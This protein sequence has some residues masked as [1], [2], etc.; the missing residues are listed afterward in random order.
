MLG[1]RTIPAAELGSGRRPQD[2][3]THHEG[4]EGHGEKAAGPLP[5]PVFL[6]VL[7]ALRGEGEPSLSLAGRSKQLGFGL[8]RQTVVALLLHQIEKRGNGRNQA[9]PVRGGNH[10][11]QPLTA[12]A[13]GLSQ[14][15]AFLV[16]DEPQVIA[17]NATIHQVAML[18]CRTIPAAELGSGRK[19]R[20]GKKIETAHP[21]HCGKGFP[22]RKS[23]Q[24]MSRTPVMG[25]ATRSGEHSTKG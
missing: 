19:T 3:L 7:R 10:R 8:G 4:H 17:R 9:A 12:N 14:T 20:S 15:P 24:A 23:V 11:G 1:C 22:S 16:V 13:P 6:R 25:S 21:D 18:G 5:L 2:R